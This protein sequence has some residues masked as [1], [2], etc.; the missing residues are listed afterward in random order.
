MNVLD[1][2][3]QEEYE[4]LARMKKAMEAE[5]K[6]LPIGYISNKKINNKDYSYL[7]KRAGDKIVSKYI[8]HSNISQ[9]KE[10]VEKRKR[11]ESSLKEI[12]ANMKKIE[13]VIK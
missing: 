3:L 5:L 9:V 13:R 2:V 4:R 8:A 1:N 11:L 12:E 6:G 7:Q 10:Q